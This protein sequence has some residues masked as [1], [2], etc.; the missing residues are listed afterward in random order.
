MHE[1][2]GNQHFVYMVFVCSQ[3]TTLGEVTHLLCT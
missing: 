2:Q 3:L 1:K